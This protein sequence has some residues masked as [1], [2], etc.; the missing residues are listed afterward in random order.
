MFRPYSAIIRLTTDGVNK[1]TYFGYTDGIPWFAWDPI[2][3]T[4]D[5]VNKGTYFGYT[6]GIPWFT[7]DPIGI[8]K[9]CTLINNICC[10]P[11]DGRIRPK[12]VAR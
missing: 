10:K 12:H 8:T 5:G 6:D 11:D 7:W 3:L 1:C 9:V 2:R 4:T